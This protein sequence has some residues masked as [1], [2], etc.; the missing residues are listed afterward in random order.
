[1]SGC[2]FTLSYFAARVGPTKTLNDR[3]VMFGKL[4]QNFETLIAKP[5]C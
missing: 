4:R 1:M 3:I 5:L 2:K